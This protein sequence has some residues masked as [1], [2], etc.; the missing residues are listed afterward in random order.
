MQPWNCIN[1]D[2]FVMRDLEN[3]QLNIKRQL[4]DFLIDF[5]RMETKQGN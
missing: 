1:D 4:P 5:L 3:K 2:N